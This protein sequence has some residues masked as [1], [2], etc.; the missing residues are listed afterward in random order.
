[1]RRKPPSL[2]TVRPNR[3]KSIFAAKVDGA[4]RTNGRCRRIA[5][6]WRCAPS[7][8]TGSTV[9]R[10]EGVGSDVARLVGS[11]RSA[12]SDVLRARE[13]P[14]DPRFPRSDG[15]PACLMRRAAAE[16]R[17]GRPRLQTSV[18]RARRLRETRFRWENVC[19]PAIVSQFRARSARHREKPQSQSN[20]TIHRSAVVEH[21]LNVIVASHFGSA[22]AQNG[23]ETCTTGL[24]ETRTLARVARAAHSGVRGGLSA[25]GIRA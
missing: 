6:A 8:G 15:C 11:N 18:G 24:G 7:Q 17:P 13:R 1:M 16:H 23:L 10:V 12:S 4:V 22:L 3:A 21:A 19:G 14:S 9:D 25:Q 5:I 20:R 2:S